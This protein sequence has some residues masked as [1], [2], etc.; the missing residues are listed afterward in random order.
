[1]VGGQGG[2][3]H[4]T[5]GDQ[6]RTAVGGEA[7]EERTDPDDA[8]RVQPV[9]GFV[10]HQH[11]RIAE[12]CGRDAEPLP[13]A[14]REGPHP[15]ARHRRQPGLLQDLRHAPYREAVAVREGEEV[16]A[17]A[18]GPMGDAR[19]EQRPDVPQRVLQG[20]EGTARRR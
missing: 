13:H 10:Q 19:V 15:L 3:G 17:G 2:L 11:G 18:P 1:M 9:G 8:L 20:A 5:A 14:E 12:Q 16:V 7:L 6:H 4:Q